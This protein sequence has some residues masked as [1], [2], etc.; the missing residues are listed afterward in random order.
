MV[1]TWQPSGEDF[2]YYPWCRLVVLDSA[3]WGGPITQINK[4]TF[5]TKVFAEALCWQRSW[6]RAKIIKLSMK[7]RRCRGQW[8]NTCFNLL[9]SGASPLRS[10]ISSGVKERGP[11]AALTWWVRNKDFQQWKFATSI[12]MS[13]RRQGFW[14]RKEGHSRLV[15][16]FCSRGTSR[17]LVW[18]LQKVITTSMTSL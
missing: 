17:R 5:M 18:W 12:C 11:R 9:Y 13:W 3:T 14:K 6:K 10:L 4:Q 2:Q 7:M 15:K 16:R 1:T 8:C